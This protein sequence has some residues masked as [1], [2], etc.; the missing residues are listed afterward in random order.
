MTNLPTLYQEQDDKYA[1]I[2]MSENYYRQAKSL[3]VTVSSLV[4]LIWFVTIIFAGGGYIAGVGVFLVAPVTLFSAVLCFA[5]KV[6]ID[7]N[8][9]ELSKINSKI[10]NEEIK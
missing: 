4:L 8:Q 2:Q 1:E 9:E 5:A 7:R 6:Q 3:G 10:M